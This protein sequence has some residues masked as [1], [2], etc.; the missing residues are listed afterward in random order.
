MIPAATARAFLDCSADNKV[1]DKLETPG[2]GT[3]LG[4]DLAMLEKG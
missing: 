4:H 1:D 2:K 3:T